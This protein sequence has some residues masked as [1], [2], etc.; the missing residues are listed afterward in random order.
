MSNEKRETRRDATK[1]N[2]C[3]LSAGLVTSSAEP[4][5]KCRPCCQRC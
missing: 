1:G 4:E 3:W 2:T 5:S